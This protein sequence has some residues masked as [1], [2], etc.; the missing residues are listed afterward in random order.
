MIA[1]LGGNDTDQ[2]PRRQ[3]HRLRRRRQGHDRPRQGQG[4]RP[5]RRRQGH[6]SRA[7]PARTEL[8]SG[9][10]AAGGPLQ[11]RRRQGRQ[12]RRL[13]DPQK[14]ALTLSL[15]RIRTP[16]LRWRSDGA[17]HAD[18]SRV[19]LRR[20]V[21]RSA[22]GRADDASS[23]SRRARGAAEGLPDPTFGSGGFT[24]LDEP[25]LHQRVPDRRRRPP[26]RQDPRRREQGRGGRLPA[27]PLQPGRQSPTS[28]SGPKG[29]RVEPDLGQRA[30]T[31]GRSTT[32]R[33]SA[34]GGS[35]PPGS[36]RGPAPEKF[37]AFAVARYLSSGQL[38]P[39]FGDA[40]LSR[41][42]PGRAGRSR[43]DGHRAGGQDRRRRRYR[44]DPLLHSE[45]AVLRLTAEGELPTRASRAA[46]PVGFRIFKIPGSES[47]EARAVRVLGDGSIVVG[48][49]IARRARSWPSSTPK[50]NRSPASAPPGSRSRTSERKPIPPGKSPTS[51]SSPTA[52]SSSP[53]QP[54]RRRTRSR[55]WSS[56]ASPPAGS[57]TRPSGRAGSSGSTRPR[58]TTKDA[59]CP[60][61]PTA[62]S[63]SPGS[64]TPATPGSCG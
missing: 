21:V 32:W 56:P 9:G 64:P 5:R 44:V 40:G 24:I 42:V 39:E 43:G 31:R 33:G 17:A 1:G 29:F 37:N 6:R 22:G 50:G 8:L 53:D 28:A 52:G 16:P 63:S 45:V 55:S 59:P 51:R 4:R 41:P 10:P 20:R 14:P 13:R 27:R 49:R 58:A 15:E 3:R 57:S 2:R 46:A 19:S 60:C 30:A 54:S 26:R 18:R 47:S 11:R 36:G 25:D 48:G 62:G 7:A 34:T 12:G 61:S 38:D 23:P 35:S